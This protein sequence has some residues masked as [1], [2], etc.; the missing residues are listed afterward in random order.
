MSAGGFTGSLY[1]T[2]SGSIVP[3]TVQPETLEMNFGGVLNE[4]GSSTVVSP[5]WPTATVSGGRR[6][7]GRIYARTIT[8][9]L[10]DQGSPPVG[11]Q[12]NGRLRIPVV[13]EALW[14]SIS[15]GS[16]VD[17]LNL[18]YRVTGKQD[19]KIT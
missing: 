13:S 4:L 5:G 6:G 19:E 8:M 12:P 10:I 14:D 3:I 18:T 2:D 11:Y 7:R 15:R 16:Q 1:E 17:Y 9:V